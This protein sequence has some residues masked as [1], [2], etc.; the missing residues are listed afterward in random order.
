MRS[1]TSSSRW[2]SR[3]AVCSGAS[4]P[5]MPRKSS[6]SAASGVLVGVV[7]DER[8]LAGVVV[9]NALGDA[10]PHLL[11]P[12]GQQGRR[13]RRREQAGDAEEVLLLGGQRLGGRAALAGV[14]GAAVQHVGEAGVG[15]QRLEL[16]HGDRLALL[17]R[18][19]SEEHTS[20][21]QPR[22]YF[23]CRLL[24]EKNT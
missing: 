2:A 18:E 14:R 10:Q 11:A 7:L 12:L 20:E 16:L 15:L 5:G 21:L 9:V 1:R 19:R 17:G 22:Q 13:L 4:R 6:S 3:D 24:L 23:V 8:Q